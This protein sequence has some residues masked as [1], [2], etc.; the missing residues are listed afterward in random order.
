MKRVGKLALL[1]LLLCVAPV[2]AQLDCPAIVQAALDATDEACRNTA[3]NQACYGN[4]T[5]VAEPQEGI[6]AFDFDERGDRVEVAAV[7]T[8]TL[9]PWSEEEWGIAL[10]K[11]QT[12]LPDT[13]PGQNVTFLLFGDV[14][15]L[16]GVETNTDPVTLEVAARGNINVR[17]G[18]STNDP[19]IGGLSEGDVVT[20]VGR[21]TDDTWLQIELSGGSRGWVSADLVDADGDISLLN[22]IDPSQPPASSLTPM[23][24]FYF[25]SGIAD[26]PCEGAPDSGILVQTPQGVG[27]IEFTVNEVNITL[28]STLYLQ[29]Q[30]SGDMH[31]YVIE[32][33]SWVQAR[34]TIVYAPAGT[35]VRVPLD[36]NGVA[37]GTPVGPQS[38]ANVD[39]AA[40]PVRILE[41]PVTIAPALTQAQIA[42]ISDPLTPAPGNWEMVIASNTCEGGSAEPV[43]VALTVENNGAAF[44]L[45]AALYTRSAPGV[46]R[47]GYTGQTGI[48]YSGT[49]QVQS[50]ETMQMDWHVAFT[51][52]TSCDTQW[53]ITLQ[54]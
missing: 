53:N 50:P 15:I 12:N 48:I 34:G 20:A 51:D 3:R 10:M 42:S 25:T 29:A 13:L 9:F 24:A 37:A 14:A 38:Y 6:A 17:S 49:I 52:G 21:N 1:I 35:M 28:G 18:P 2:A 43:E 8:L 45:G 19:R 40:L 32:G 47:Y 36:G 7:R 54:A 27:R 11:L 22:V 31:I 4:I 26:A 5:L 30:P 23:Q 39:L 44:N 16:S 46:Y 33:Q 41:Q